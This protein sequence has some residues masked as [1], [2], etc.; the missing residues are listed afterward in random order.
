MA[1]RPRL[2]SAYSVFHC[3]IAWPI[4]CP[5]A[6]ATCHYVGTRRH[7][8]R[9]DT[10]TLVVGGYQPPHRRYNILIIVRSIEALTEFPYFQLS[11]L[12]RCN[13]LR[14]TDGWRTSC[15]RMEMVMPKPSG[16][17]RLY[18]RGSLDLLRHTITDLSR[19]TCD[20]T[21]C[22]TPPLVV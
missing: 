15:L 2:P 14:Y 8:G 7:R 11:M 20:C 10:L 6:S 12:P 4:D 19:L 21:P 17:W 3:V 16:Q 22:I 9:H 1:Q 18:G 5:Y 13:A